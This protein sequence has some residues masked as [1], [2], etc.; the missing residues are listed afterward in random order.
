MTCHPERDHTLYNRNVS[1]Y[2]KVDRLE[3][4]CTDMQQAIFLKRPKQSTQ[5][6]SRSIKES[7]LSVHVRGFLL[8]FAPPYIRI[9]ELKQNCATLNLTNLSISVAFKTTRVATAKIHNC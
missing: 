9:E 6:L 1:S 5:N 8:F 2:K 7:V 3:Q 4:L